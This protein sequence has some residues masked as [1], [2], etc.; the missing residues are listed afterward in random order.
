[1]VPFSLW[2]FAL[3]VNRLIFNYAIVAIRRIL[4]SKRDK[5]ARNRTTVST[6]VIFLLSFPFFF[7]LSYHVGTCT[8]RS[9]NLE[10]GW[11]KDI[12]GRI[13]FDSFLLY[14]VVVTEIDI[15]HFFFSF[16]FKHRTLQFYNMYITCIILYK[17]INIY[18]T[19]KN[20]N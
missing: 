18:T 3:L 15:F 17:Y 12:R 10:S 8:Q 13:E 5:H 11:K 2:L 16:C 9:C 14:T 7:S 4:T 6:I 1:M 20:D 19:I